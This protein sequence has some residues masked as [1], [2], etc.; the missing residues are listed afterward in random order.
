VTRVAG[1]AAV[2]AGRDAF[3]L[4][5]DGQADGVDGAGDLLQAPVVDEQ[6]ARDG[7]EGDFGGLAPGLFAGCDVD[8]LGDER[9]LDGVDAGRGR[10]RQACLMKPARDAAGAA[11][12]RVSLGDQ[13]GAAG[14]RG[15]A[16]LAQLLLLTG[17][18]FQLAGQRG[19]ECQGG[20]LLSAR[21]NVLEH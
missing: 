9:Q 7:V 8:E 13:V 6:N 15:P 10:D 21:R 17:Q 5:A 4:N 1:L 12:E 11:S 14:L 20:R 18:S 16:L 3:E 2:R 19:E